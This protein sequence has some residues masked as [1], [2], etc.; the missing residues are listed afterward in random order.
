MCN[1]IFGNSFWKMIPTFRHVLPHRFREN[2]QVEIISRSFCVVLEAVVT[3]CSQTPFLNLLPL[4]SVSK[5]WRELTVALN[6]V[7]K[8]STGSYRQQRETGIV[9]ICSHVADNKKATAS[10]NTLQIRDKAPLKVRKT[11]V[12]Y[13]LCYYLVSLVESQC[14]K[15]SF[16]NVCENP[17]IIRQLAVGL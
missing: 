14:K 5:A 16:Y 1:G 4:L 10:C 12:K 3:L 2:L 8:S 13:L 7:K 9:T 11:H 6:N 17:D 15:C